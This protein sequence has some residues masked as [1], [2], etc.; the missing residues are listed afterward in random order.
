MGWVFWVF[1]Q[2][3]SSFLR[4][5]GHNLGLWVYVNNN[6]DTVLTKSGV[7]LKHFLTEV[8]FKLFETG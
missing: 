8:S 2:I 3:I 7:N 5:L 4:Q 1:G 6:F